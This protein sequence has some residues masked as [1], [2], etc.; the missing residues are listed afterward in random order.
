MI[1]INCRRVRRPAFTLIEL[2]CTIAIIAVLATLLLGPAGRVLKRVR[3]D[4]WADKASAQLE[5]VKA[6][7][8]SRYQGQAD[9]P[10]VTLERLAAEDALEPSQ[11]RFLRDRRVGFVPFSGADPTNFVVVVVR[12]ERGF[13]TGA[14]SLVL[15]KGEL[16]APPP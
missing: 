16:V 9:F 13:F 10:T 4:D 6:R 8:R 5:G 3:A 12:I 14:E 7:L 15:T 2:L 1:P 11:L